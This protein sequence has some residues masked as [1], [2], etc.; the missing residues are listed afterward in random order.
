MV[1]KK[2]ITGKKYSVK[3]I[4]SNEKKSFITSSDEEMD[5]RAK[6]A[7]KSAVKKAKVCKKPVA[8][9]DLKTKKAYIEYSN[10]E[11]KYVG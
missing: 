6:H 2:V 7:V 11:R 5:N 10:G 4:N 8:K 3:V 1:E 9:Y